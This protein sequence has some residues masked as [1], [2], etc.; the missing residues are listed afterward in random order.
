MSS[1]SQRIEMALQETTRGKDEGRGNNR[2][3]TQLWDLQEALVCTGF[4]ETELGS[5]WH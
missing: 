2:D 3:L 5:H 1:G 4:T